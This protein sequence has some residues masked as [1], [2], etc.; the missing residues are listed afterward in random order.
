LA[1]QKAKSRV[2]E[3]IELL[4]Q[5]EYA[6]YV[7]SEPQVPD[8]EYDRCFLELESLEKKY[9]ELTM[10]FSPTQRVGGK[11]VSSFG[12]VQHAVPMLSLA[13]AFSDKEV[14]DFDRRCREHLRIKNIDYVVEL[15][16]DGLAVSLSYRDGVL[17]KAATRG[18]GTRGEDVTQ[19]VRGIGSIP[20]RL[21][22][23]D[24]PS[25]VEIRGEIFMPLPGFMLLNQH[26]KA[27]G[28][29][30]YV[31]P[32]NAAAGSLRQLDSRITRS[33]PLEIFCY[34]VGAIEGG[35]MP[36]SHIE[37]LDALSNWGLRT[38]PETTLAKGPLDCLD[39]YLN[40][41]EKRHDLDYEIDGLVYKVNSYSHQDALGS[42]SRAPR[43]A[44]AHKFPAQEELTRVR[45][46]EIQIGRTGAA[47]PVARL[48]SVF[49]GGATV[50]NA[51]LH[52]FEEI[53][54]LDVRIGD[55]VVVRRAGDV[56]PEVIGVLLESRP[57]NSKRYHFPKKCP[58]CNSEIVKTDEGPLMRCS[59]GLICN[60]QITESIRHFASRKAMDIDGMGSK[61]IEQMVNVGLL[62]TVSDVYRLDFTTI[63]ELDRSGKKSAENLMRA[64][65]A[66]RETTFSRFL[67][68]L[69]IPQVGEKTAVELAQK[70]KSIDSL[71]DADSEL[72][73]AIPDIGPIVA[74]NITHFF[75]E[76][77][78][79]RIVKEL[80]SA[81][82][83]WSEPA[84][85]DSVS[86]MLEG[87]TIVVTG[88]L[89]SMN[90]AQAQKI[91]ASL[92]AEVSS[93]ISKKTD[94]LIAGQNAGSKL[95]KAIDLGVE[96]LDEQEFY[97]L[98]TKAGVT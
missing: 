41:V 10:S 37:M 40:F 5:Y 14:M 64:I 2:K 56:I 97:D 70:F 67:Y 11:P 33:R 27:V 74:S 42:V 17:L 24:W 62:K 86:D 51:T 85:I 60:A 54:R 87:K 12:E 83:V 65:E 53:R 92:G 82:I 68:S 4:E 46:I 8:V 31:N 75:S 90:R 91:L 30:V 45:N 3:L 21:R 19:N 94:M 34:G 32:R 48:D 72:L 20:L 96:I 9:P 1:T 66:S 26:Q 81:G 95:N 44:L 28:E 55:T 98:L 39:K 61:I 29:K 22:G 15:K 43:W 76:P 7:L 79:Q 80:L 18:D 59:G 50:S 47:T 38:N 78:N 58:V 36:D 93:T 49:V 77:H 35:S 71:I 63:A 89:S 13:N 88:T 25:F 23:S 57:K 69:G 6:Y 52:N 84:P 73:Q 16:L